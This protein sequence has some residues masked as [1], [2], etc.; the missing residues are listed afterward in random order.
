MAIGG[1][2]AFLGDKELNV[3]SLKLGNEKAILNPF[4]KPE[5]FIRNDAFSASLEFAFPGTL[6]SNLGMNSFNSDIALI[7]K[8]TGNARNAQPTGSGQLYPSQSLVSSGSYDWASNGYET[9][10]FISGAQNLTSIP[11]QSL[12]PFGSNKFVFEGWFNFQSPISAVTPPFN[13]FFFGNISGDSIL[14]DISGISNR[15]R[16]NMGGN[17]NITAEPNYTQN[18]WYHLAFVRNA[19]SQ[20]I[21]LN[22]QRIGNIVIGSGNVPYANGQTDWDVLGS[23]GIN[24]GAAKLAQD[25]RLYIGTDKNYTASIITPPE[26]MIYTI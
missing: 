23:S 16:F 4:T 7:I 19:T 12:G 25:V 17:A 14:L 21:Y 6:A 8:G 20:S 9:S 24:D 15:Y 5:F 3:S 11:T 18:I 2:M 10:L 13:Q 1:T 22:G 26:S